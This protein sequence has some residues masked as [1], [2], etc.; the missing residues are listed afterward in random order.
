MELYHCTAIRLSGVDIKHKDNFAPYQAYMIIMYV[1]VFIMLFLSR[2]EIYC[3]CVVNS[4]S[5]MK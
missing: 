4:D 1:C 5:N 2:Y 3:M